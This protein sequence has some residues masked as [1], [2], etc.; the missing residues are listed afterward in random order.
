MRVFFAGGGTAGH[1]YAGVALADRLRVH[2]PQVDVQFVGAAGG[3]EERLVPKSGY[4]LHLIHIGSWNGA[5]L[6]KKILT[7]FQLPLACLKSTWLLL[8]YRPQIIFGVGGYASFPLVLSAGLLGWIWGGRVAI[9]EQNVLP[10]LTNRLLGRV[11]K[12][13]FSAFPGSE[14]IFGKKKVRVTGNPVRSAMK[15]LI[16]ALRDPFTIFIFGG[17][18]GAVGINSLVIEALP[19]LKHA[20]R[21]H[22]ISLRWIH[23][24]G[25]KD[26]DRVFEAHSKNQSGARVERFIDNMIDCYSQSSLLICRAG[27]STLSEIAAV[28][29][30]SILIPLVSRDRHQEYNAE[31]FQK[32]G[33]SQVLLQKETTGEQL[34]NHII[35]LA[36]S[37]ERIALMEK[38]ALEFSR[39]DAVEQILGDFFIES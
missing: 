30:A 39:L 15:P 7:A 22:G 38:K 33:A 28:G 20:K 17:S 21:V 32:S 10:G 12:R 5:S 4:A 13:V 9:L 37:S 35:S 27:S 26:Y 18:Q 16:A 29:R 3:M 19:F 8:R 25:Q 36:K 2:Q 34:A 31:L 6:R 23:Q 11:S 24:T 1:I 14:S